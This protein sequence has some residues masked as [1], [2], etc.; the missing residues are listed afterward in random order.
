MQITDACNACFEQGQIFTQ[1][2]LAKVL[3]QLVF[4]YSS[5]NSTSH[6]TKL[7]YW[8]LVI[9]SRLFVQVEQI[10]LPLLFMRTVLQTIGAFPSLVRYFDSFI[11]ITI[12]IEQISDSLCLCL[13]KSVRIILLA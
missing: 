3:N 9:N 5:W 12:M 1:Q 6:K 10:P 13:F 4:Q 11:T 8:Y 2:V 7:C